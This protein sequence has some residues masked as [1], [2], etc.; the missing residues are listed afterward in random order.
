VLLY[1]LKGLQAVRS[2]SGYAD[3]RMLTYDEVKTLT[4]NCVVISQYNGYGRVHGAGVKE[5]M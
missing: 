2:F 5:V 1:Q 3:L 4:Q